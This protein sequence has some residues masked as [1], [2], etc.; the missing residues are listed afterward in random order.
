MCRVDRVL[1][2]AACAF[3]HRREG[4]VVSHPLWRAILIGRAIRVELT[5][6]ASWATHVLLLLL[7][8]RLILVHHAPRLVPTLLRA[9]SA[10]SACHRWQL[11]VIVVLEHSI[12]IRGRFGVWRL[13]CAILILLYCRLRRS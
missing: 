4:Y 12:M 9:V 1:A 3:A 6:D 2:G 11:T 7:D 10:Q 8:L 5:V 13:H